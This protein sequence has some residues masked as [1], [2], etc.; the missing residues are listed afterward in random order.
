MPTQPGPLAG[1]PCPPH[2][3]PQHGP[4]C[5][6]GAQGGTSIYTPEPNRPHCP[7]HRFGAEQGHGDMSHGASPHADVSPTHPAPPAVWV[8]VRSEG[9]HRPEAEGLPPG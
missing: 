5:A 4:Q 6:G 1:A 2:T 8:P 3:V 9:R 7:E